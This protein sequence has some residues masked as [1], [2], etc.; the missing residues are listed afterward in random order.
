[1]DVKLK[2]AAVLL[3]AGALAACGTEEA[4]P[5]EADVAEETTEETESVSSDTE[6]AEPEEAAEE[7]PAVEETDSAEEPAPEEEPAEELAEE[8]AQAAPG[9]TAALAFTMG[10]GAQEAEAVYTESPE[11]SYI[12]ALLPEF[13]LTSEEPNKDVLYWTEN[14]SVFMRIETFA[15]GEIDFAFAADAMEQTLQAVNPEGEITESAAIDPS[16][17]V[18]A[19]ALEVP[20]DNGMV[21]GAVYETADSIVRLTI[22]DTAE[23]NATDAFVSMAETI[24]V[25]PAE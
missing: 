8:P 6:A 11:Q 18:N 22:Y 5:A 7:E 16:A 3:S 23:A 17:Y 13:E 24:Q 4:G 15:P 10:S 14:D 21:T 9:E 1:M 25:Q 2:F 12:I 19:K 20:T